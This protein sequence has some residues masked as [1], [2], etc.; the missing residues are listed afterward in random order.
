MTRPAL[1]VLLA[2]LGGATLAATAGACPVCY[3]EADSSV[4]DGARWAVVFLGALVY[5]LMGGGVAMVVMS[6][7]R[8]RRRGEPAAGTEPG[9][10]SDATG[11]ER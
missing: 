11:G 9:P 8:L 5:A 1:A 10:C 6:R 3:G 7:R 2:L 4:L